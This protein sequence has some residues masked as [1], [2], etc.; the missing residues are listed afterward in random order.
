MLVD[1]MAGKEG[2]ANCRYGLAKPQHAYQRHVVC[3]VIDPPVYDGEL[4]IERKDDEKTQREEPSE[5]R[6]F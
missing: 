5:I 6:V 4:H 2:A 1:K 3:E